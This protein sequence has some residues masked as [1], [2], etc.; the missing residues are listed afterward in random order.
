LLDRSQRPLQLTEAGEIFSQFAIQMVNCADHLGRSIR[1]LAAGVT[2]EVRIG[3]TTSIG[4]FM[5]PKIVTYLLQEMPKVRLDITIAALSSVCESV[6]QAETDFGI[7]L[8]QREPQGLMTKILKQERLCFLVSPRHPL[9]KKT[10]SLEDLRQFS[11]VLGAKT[12]GYTGMIERLLERYGLVGFDVALRVGSFE[13]IKET[14]QAGLGIGVL[15]GFMVQRE[16][17][18]GTLAEIIARKINFTANIILV[19]RP[20]Y[21]PTPTVVAVKAFVEGRL[22]S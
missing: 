1:E 10:V 14:V 18:N 15:P 21:T 4:A 2:G 19:E 16:L 8:S 12:G 13:V 17:R 11:F 6:K 3:T 5:L 20:K 9:A 7:I 22:R